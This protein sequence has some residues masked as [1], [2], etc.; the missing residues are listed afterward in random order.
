VCDSGGLYCV[1]SVLK[2][3]RD[4][5]YPLLDKAVGSTGAES[6]RFFP[7]LTVDRTRELA[8]SPWQSDN[9]HL[10]FVL[11]L[12]QHL[13][14]ENRQL[15]YQSKWAASAVSEVLRA[16]GVHVERSCAYDTLTEELTP[17]DS[18]KRIIIYAPSGGSFTS[19]LHPTPY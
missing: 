15:H 11:R 18:D 14:L 5:V 10:S 8:D 2:P 6:L 16:R 4:G 1:R 9:Q 19:P 7:L 17:S 3:C 12:L 13:G